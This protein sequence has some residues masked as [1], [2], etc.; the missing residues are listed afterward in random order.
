M[1]VWLTRVLSQNCTVDRSPQLSSTPLFSR[2]PI[3]WC[4]W[5]RVYR[6]CLKLLNTSGLSRHSLMLMAASADSLE[7]GWA[8][9]CWIRS[10]GRLCSCRSSMINVS[11]FRIPFLVWMKRLGAS[12]TSSKLRTTSITYWLAFGLYS[13]VVILCWVGIQLALF[14]I[15]CSGSIQSPNPLFSAGLVINLLTLSFIAGFVINLL[16]V[17]SCWNCIELAYFVIYCLVC[18][19]LAHFVIYC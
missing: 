16:T 7:D 10:Q 9:P 8:G 4:L 5:P 6:W 12:I 15:L 13:I 19:E 3:V 17:I 1:C 11:F 18:I 14:I 2:R